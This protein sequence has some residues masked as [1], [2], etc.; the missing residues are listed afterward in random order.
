MVTYGQLDASEQT[1]VKTQPKFS[2]FHEENELEK[3]VCKNGGHFVQVSKSQ[4][5]ELYAGNVTEDTSVYCLS[6]M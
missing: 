5:Q 1:S 6:E 2:T 3:G 4:M